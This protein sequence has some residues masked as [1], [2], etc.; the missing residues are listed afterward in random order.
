MGGEMRVLCARVLQVRRWAGCRRGIEGRNPIRVGMTIGMASGEREQESD[1]E[2]AE[3]KP[4][5]SREKRA[6]GPRVEESW[7]EDWGEEVVAGRGVIAGS[8]R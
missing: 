7:S 8:A 3:E 6:R 1:Y 4:P 2:S 5:D